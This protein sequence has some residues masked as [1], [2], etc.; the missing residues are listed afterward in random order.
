MRDR[1]QVLTSLGRT[2][3]GVAFLC[4]IGSAGVGCQQSSKVSAER[5]KEHVVFLGRSVKADVEEIRAGLP[6]GA[7]HV[8]EYLA[9]GKFEDAQAAS[10]VLNRA[11]N[12]VQDLRV[13]KSTFFA[14][15]DEQGLIIRSDQ[16]QDG[17]AGK[18]LFAAFPEA[19]SALTGK[20]V[21]TRGSIPE[22]SR[23]RGRSDAQ[24]L[25]VT[26]VKSPGSDAVRG[27]YATGWSWSAY[28]YRLE[29]QLRSSVRSA[30][31]ERENEPLVY[32]YVVA[33]KEVFGAPISPEIN[34]H[35]VAKQNFTAASGANGGSEPA[36][37][38]LEITGRDFG[39]AFLGTPSLG[40]DVGI[41][42]LRS[43]T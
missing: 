20:Y 43:E 3:A 36:T 37:L 34:A 25:A 14:L 17:L 6:K 1:R 22:A 12:K 19:K 21:E 8:R 32:V 38:Q 40:S 26:G 39:M 41:V 23:V 4:A 15:V 30:L 33:G 16:E 24:W 10:E 2:I 31:R 18:S 7:E 11:R 28:A 42:V 27:L 35:M 5:A 13:A 9:L 29:N